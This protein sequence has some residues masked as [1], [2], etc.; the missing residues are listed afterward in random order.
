[1]ANATFS[2]LYELPKNQY[3][4]GCPVIVCAGAL[5]KM[6]DAGLLIAQLKLEALTDK[7]ISALIV[8]LTLFDVLGQEKGTKEF[9]YLDL[10]INRHQN[11]G[12]QTPIIIEQSEIRRFS[13]AVKNVVFEDNSVW[14]NDEAVIGHTLPETLPLELSQE[15]KEQYKRELNFTSEVWK[16]QEFDQL[17]QCGC[18]CWNHHSEQVCHEC[19]RSF[20]IQKNLSSEENL[21]PLLQ[22]YKEKQESDRIQKEQTEK[23]RAESKAQAEAAA[24]QAA[25]KKKKKMMIAMIACVCLLVLSGVL[26]STVMKVIPAKKYQQAMD[27]MDAGHYDEASALFAELGDYKDAS[28]RIFQPYYKQALALLEAGKQ[29]EGIQLLLSIRTKY[30]N[31]NQKLTS[32]AEGYVEQEKYREAIQLFYKIGNLRRAYELRYTHFYEGRIAVENGGI[33]CISNKGIRYVNDTGYHPTDVHRYGSI[34]EDGVWNNTSDMIAL[35]VCGGRQLIGL[36]SDGTADSLNWRLDNRLTLYDEASVDKWTDLVSVSAGKYFTVGLS[37]YGT[38]KLT[39]F[40][41]DPSLEWRDIV[42]VSAGAHHVV[43]LKEDGTVVT[44]VWD[45]VD[46]RNCNLEEADNW[47]NIVAVATSD[48]YTVGLKENGTVVCTSLKRNTGTNERELLSGW[49]D[50]VAIKGTS[51]DYFYGVKKD[52]TVVSTRQNETLSTW[53]NI[54]NIFVANNIVIGVQRDGTLLFEISPYFCGT[55]QHPNRCT[56]VKEW[57]IEKDKV[58][59]LPK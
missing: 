19:K 49:H 16:L 50:I 6:E 3:I 56:F 14:T 22:K 8:S 27:M 12:E 37:N 53:S 17:W 40:F 35:A 33:Y 36:N 7:K 43:G 45:E 54:V 15:Y 52:G 44:Q 57:T 55:A 5:L 28:K 48:H 41:R 58:V 20:E 46:L 42:E 21:K 31:A 29:N 34:I 30:N 13:V 26:I 47:T 25:V 2:R 9:Q 59:T 38:V 1:M 51:L 10:N 18:G 32:I 39:G 23:A 24:Q 11:F 4:N